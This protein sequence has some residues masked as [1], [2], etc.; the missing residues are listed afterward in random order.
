VGLR[1][2][3]SRSPTSGTSSDT[4]MANLCRWL[5]ENLGSE[6]KHFCGSYDEGY[7]GSDGCIVMVFCANQL[8]ALEEEQPEV[9]LASRLRSVNLFTQTTPSTI[10]WISYAPPRQIPSSRGGTWKYQLTHFTTEKL[11]SKLITLGF[12]VVEDLRPSQFLCRYFP[13]PLSDEGEH[14]VHATTL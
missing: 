11:R 1:I 12:S 8:S 10:W 2:G 6:Q 7:A 9:E 4:P 13:S 5:H 3:L 14:L